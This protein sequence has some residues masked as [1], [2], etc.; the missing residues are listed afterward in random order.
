MSKDFPDDGPVIGLRQADPTE[1]IWLEINRGR[2]YHLVLN[3]LDLMVAE[4]EQIN[5]KSDFR[6]CRRRTVGRCRIWAGIPPFVKS[7]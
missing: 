2:G 7:S 4:P 6:F 3:R 1:K 5:R